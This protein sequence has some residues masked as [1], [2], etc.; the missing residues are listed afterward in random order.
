[1]GDAVGNVFVVSDLCSRS[2]NE[3]RSVA[4]QSACTATTSATVGQ[5]QASS[6]YHRSVLTLID[7]GGAQRELLPTRSMTQYV[8]S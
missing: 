8:T 4:A 7:R 2:R 1:M 3:F 5:H 6:S